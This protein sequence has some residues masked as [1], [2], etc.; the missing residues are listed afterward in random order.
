MTRFSPTWWALWTWELYRPGLYDD[1]E[2]P[3][4]YEQPY[5]RR[6]TDNGY[7]PAS[8]RPSWNA[9][10]IGQGYTDVP[11]LTDSC[12]GYAGSCLFT[13]ENEQR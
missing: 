4:G 10:L 11:A 2:G 5:G 1:D 8:K 7:D 6:Y 9:M 12:R 13:C 3:E